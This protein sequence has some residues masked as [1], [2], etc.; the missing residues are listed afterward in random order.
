MRS[1]R[2]A[3]LNLSK[4]WFYYT[5]GDNF[6]RG[7]AT[8]R[9][10]FMEIKNSINNKAYIE[11]ENRANI[12]L[13]PYSSAKNLRRIIQ[14]WTKDKDY[15]KNDNK[16]RI[17]VY[18]DKPKNCDFGGNSFTIYKRISMNEK[19]CLE[20][21]LKRCRKEGEPEIKLAYLADKQKEDKYSIKKMSKKRELIQ[22]Y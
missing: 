20:K 11:T 8:R 16:K 19:D 21:M 12:L 1:K 5:N 2:T 15:E 17:E 7:G 4:F 13:I 18:C 10:I 22:S 14:E 6:E 9:G 3:E